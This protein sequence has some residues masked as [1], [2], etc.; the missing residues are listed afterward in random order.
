MDGICF[1]S[2]KG[3]GFAHDKILREIRFVRKAQGRFPAKPPT[4]SILHERKARKYLYYCNRFIRSIPVLR[5][6]AKR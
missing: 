5:R 6:L 3:S 1:S 2:L 4:G